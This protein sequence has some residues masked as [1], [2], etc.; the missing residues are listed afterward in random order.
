MVFLGCVLRR[1][2]IAK[3]LARA[4]PER[5]IVRRD[6]SRVAPSASK[7]SLERG[8]ASREL[9]STRGTSER[10]M[11]SAARGGGNQKLASFGAGR[12]GGRRRVGGR[13]RA[14]FAS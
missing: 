9:G 2:A 6:R 3:I 4:R 1:D 5:V 7:S 10:L 12:M 14:G 8:G 11:R 13:I